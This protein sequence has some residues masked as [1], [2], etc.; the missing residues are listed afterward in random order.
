[1]ENE[2]LPT[3]CSLIYWMPPDIYTMKSKKE[4]NDY[5]RNIILVPNSPFD[6]LEIPKQEATRK[7][8]IP[9]E[10]I[11]RYGNYL[12]NTTTQEKRRNAHII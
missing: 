10:A 2:Y 4:Y 12:I 5:D 8:A 7:R 6:N 1:M 11:K 9:A 3:E